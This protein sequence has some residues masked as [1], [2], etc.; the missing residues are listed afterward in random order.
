MAF[1]FKGKVQQYRQ[2]MTRSFACA[3][4]FLEVRVI[5]GLT[6]WDKFTEAIVWGSVAAAYPIADLVLQWQESHRSR[7]VSG[8]REQARAASAS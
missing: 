4:I 3:L 7:T 6:G 2:W 5:Q 8:R 1:I